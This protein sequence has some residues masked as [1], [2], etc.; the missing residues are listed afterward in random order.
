MTGT[1]PTLQFLT[2]VDGSIDEGGLHELLARGLSA[3]PYRRNSL[4]ARGNLIEI[5]PN[6]EAD[7]ELARTDE[8]DFLYFRWRVEATPTD[9]TIGEAEQIALARDIV[10][11]VQA[12]R[13]RAIVCAAFEDKV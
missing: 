3:T 8:D 11:V 12:D 9:R 6:E 1:G 2:M 7:A 5:Q 10:R 13:L 4:H